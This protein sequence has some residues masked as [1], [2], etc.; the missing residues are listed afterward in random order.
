MKKPTLPLTEDE[1]D[2]LQDIL[3]DRIDE[4]LDTTGTDEGVC[5]LDELDGFLT[6]LVSGP[7]AVLPSVWLPFLWGDYPPQWKAPEESGYFMSLLRRH[8]NEIALTLQQDLDGFEPYFSYYEMDGE[9]F[10]I[11]DDW[12]EGYMRGVRVLQGRWEDGHPRVTELLAPIRAFTSE[13][14]WAG[15]ELPPEDADAQCDA[16]LVNVRELYRYWQRG[17]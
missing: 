14:E 3:L 7:V 13:T 2:D 16:I 11:V 12:C 17:S 4:D 10:D 15:H 8:Q 1:L 9:A 6:A 5:L